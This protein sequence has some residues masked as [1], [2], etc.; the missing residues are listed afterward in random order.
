M[1]AGGCLLL[2]YIGPELLDALFGLPN[3][4]SWFQ[5]E[6][7]AVGAVLNGAPFAII[8]VTPPEFF[9]LEPGQ[10]VDVSIPLTS[11]ATVQPQFAAA[12]SPFDVLAAPFRH[13]LH[14]MV[15]LRDGQTEVQA[16]A[17]LISDRSTSRLCARRRRE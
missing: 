8:G 5:K 2:P 10:S 7:P 6:T 15:R 12:G 16:L 1:G 17:K 11:V 9:G 13:W 14:L 3:T 4:W